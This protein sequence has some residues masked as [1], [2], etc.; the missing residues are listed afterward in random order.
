M[1]HEPTSRIGEVQFILPESSFELG[2][3]PGPMQ[4]KRSTVTWKEKSGK[5]N[6][7]ELELPVFDTKKPTSTR[8]KVLVYT[9]QPGGSV[10]VEL[11]E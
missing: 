8:A 11:K 7:T 3:S 6:K 5:L 1:H 4:A 2:F 9:I 10:T